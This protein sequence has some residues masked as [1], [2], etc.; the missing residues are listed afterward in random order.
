MVFNE[1]QLANMYYNQKKEPKVIWEDW[2]A[3]CKFLL[4]P[5]EEIQTPHANSF[6]K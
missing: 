6:C 4:S 3:S 2:T 1:S 5:M